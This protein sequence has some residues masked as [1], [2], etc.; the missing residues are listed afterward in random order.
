M[1]FNP[2]AL[3]SPVTEAEILNAIHEA[4]AELRLIQATLSNMLTT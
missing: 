1:K 2:Y 4:I 3:V